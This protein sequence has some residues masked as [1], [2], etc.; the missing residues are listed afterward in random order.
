[1]LSANGV[2]LKQGD[3]VFTIVKLLRDHHTMAYGEIIKVNPK[4]VMIKLYEPAPKTKWNVTEFRRTPDQV[5][6]I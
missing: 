6:A 2:E 5:V 4:T 1:M 3:I